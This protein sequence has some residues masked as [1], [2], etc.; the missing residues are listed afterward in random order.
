MLISNTST[1][2]TKYLQAESLKL[3]SNPDKSTEV[4]I[5]LVHSEAAIAPT[6]G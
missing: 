6:L 2:H 1:Q 4:C 5:Y 3:L